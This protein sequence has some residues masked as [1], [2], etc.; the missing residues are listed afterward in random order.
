MRGVKGEY[1]IV[2]VNIV[3]YKLRFFI[4]KWN[5]VIKIVYL[6]DL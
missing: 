1:D 3:K 5:I 4:W 2:F 6:W